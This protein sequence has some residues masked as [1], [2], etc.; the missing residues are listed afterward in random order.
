MHPSESQRLLKAVAGSD[1]ALI[2]VVCRPVEPARWPQF[3]AMASLQ[4]LPVTGR[5]LASEWS[6][7][8]PDWVPVFDGSFSVAIEVGRQTWTSCLW[9]SSCVDLQGDP[10]DV[11]EAQDVDDIVALIR[12]LSSVTQTPVLLLPET[13]DYEATPP[14]LVIES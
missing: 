9:D 14:Y 10:R 3:L 13:S 6:P 2:E 4:G 5:D 8:R 7:L 1:G 11:R 12:I